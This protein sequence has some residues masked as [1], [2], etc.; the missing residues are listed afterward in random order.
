MGMDGAWRVT[1]AAPAVLDEGCMLATP[2]SHGSSAALSRIALLIGRH[3]L[4]AQ[5]IT[6]NQQACRDCESCVYAA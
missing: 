4:P 1:A 5:N 2:H 6:T 3:G